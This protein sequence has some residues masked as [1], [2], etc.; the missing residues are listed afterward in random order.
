[1]AKQLF[2][3]EIEQS[4]LATLIQYPETYVEIPF[5]NSK[6]FSRQNSTLYWLPLLSGQ[7]YTS[8]QFWVCVFQF[9]PMAKLVATIPSP[10][11]NSRVGMRNL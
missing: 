8:E 4:I 9:L 6:D 10:L 3:L 1:M 11:H 2:S 5:I 7:N